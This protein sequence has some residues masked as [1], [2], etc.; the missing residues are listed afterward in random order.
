MQI[1]WT[2]LIR[3]ARNAHMRH[4]ICDLFC[5]QQ[6]KSHIWLNSN[7]ARLVFSTIHH[8]LWMFKCAVRFLLVGAVRAHVSTRHTKIMLARA[9]S[10]TGVYLCAPLA[11]LLPLPV[12][13]GN[14]KAIPISSGKNLPRTGKNR[15]PHRRRG[16]PVINPLFPG[17]RVFWMS[18]RSGTRSDS[19]YYVLIQRR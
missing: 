3:R 14:K 7:S 10:Q 11:F 17:R 12:G 8:D 6:A 4:R 18:A 19:S 2:Q 13:T 16:R 15:D 9:I 5:T 1:I